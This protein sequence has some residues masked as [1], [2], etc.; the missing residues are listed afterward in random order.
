MV[1]GGSVESQ[2]AE[3]AGVAT[4][5]F[6][7]A[8]K[9]D[10]VV[11][12]T[13]HPFPQFQWRH[14][15]EVGNSPRPSEGQS[16]RLDAIGGAEEPPRCHLAREPHRAGRSATAR[17]CGGSRSN[18]VMSSSHWPKQSGVEE[19][20]RKFLEQLLQWIS[21]SNKQLQD[22]GQRYTV[23][24]FKLHQFISQTGSVYTTLD[25]DE[26][27]FITLEPGLYKQ[28]EKD[29][30]P[31]FT[32]RLQPFQWASVHLRHVNG[33]RME[34]REFRESPAKMRTFMMAT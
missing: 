18:L 15:V 19:E 14:A 29:K 20:A 28:D 4:K 6:G 22:S 8:F 10:Q 13:L 25:Q 5:L 7:R 30:K 3:V 27:R 21:L 33:D 16:V 9:A 11:N 26:H 2:R 23:L 32:E 1:S 24:P 12:E 34:P 17:S 31:I